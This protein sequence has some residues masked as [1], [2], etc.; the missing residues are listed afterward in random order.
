[1]K[2]SL[3][4]SIAALLLSAGLASAQNSVTLQ[5]DPNSAAEEVAGYK[6][7]QK[8]VTAPV[9]PATTPPVVTWKLVGQTAANVTKFTVQNIAPGTTT[10]AVTA[11]KGDTESDR[12]N[13]VSN[14]LLLAPKGLKIV[15]IAVT[16]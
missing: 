4:A 14:T 5:W 3:I 6:L 11:F 1:M 15:T 7:Y 13:E 2:L 16:P 9:P 10:Y 12:S 8:V